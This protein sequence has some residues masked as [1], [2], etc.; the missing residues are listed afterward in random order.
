MLFVTTSFEVNNYNASS[1]N[2]KRKFVSIILNKLNP[3]STTDER[4]MFNSES[5]KHKM[6]NKIVRLKYFLLHVFV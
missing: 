1:S 6:M 2:V 3:V 5:L 4:V